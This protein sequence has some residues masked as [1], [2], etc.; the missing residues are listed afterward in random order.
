MTATTK[1]CIACGAS[2]KRSRTDST[3]RCPACRAAIRDERRGDGGRSVET[4]NCGKTVIATWNDK[5]T[6][7][8]PT[9]WSCPRECS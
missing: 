6:V 5:M 1:R 2:F 9:G 3:V 7:R 8:T 4:C